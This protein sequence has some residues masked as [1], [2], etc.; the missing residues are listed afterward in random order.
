MSRP[1]DPIGLVTSHT[2]SNQQY[3]TRLDD[4]ILWFLT[5]QVLRFDFA[6][7]AQPNQLV[8]VHCLGADEAAGQV[9]MDV[10]GSLEAVPPSRS[11]QLRTS[12]SPAVK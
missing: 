9:G 11:I 8:G 5:Q 2:E 1:N 3:V 12:F 6:F 10:V 4:V 7:A